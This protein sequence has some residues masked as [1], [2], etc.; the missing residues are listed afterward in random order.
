MSD[1]NEDM[2]KGKRERERTTKALRCVK[3]G[4]IGG[5]CSTSARGS[6]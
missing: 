1:S 6:F 5:G 2:R 3:G 4:G